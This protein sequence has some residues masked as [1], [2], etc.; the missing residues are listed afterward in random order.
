MDFVHDQLANGRTIRVLTVVDDFTRESVALEVATSLPAAVVTQALD[1]AIAQRKAC[2]KSLTCDN[3]TEFTS[4]V[5]MQWAA[6]HGI[7]VQFIDPGKPTQNA[8]VES[9]N[10]RLRDECLNTNWFAT[11]DAARAVIAT[12][13]HHYNYGRPHSSLG[14]VPPAIFASNQRPE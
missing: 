11:L 2:P 1:R 12:W 6:R 4:M 13:Q 7:D 14:R 5:F 10:G 8:F 9:F 3:G